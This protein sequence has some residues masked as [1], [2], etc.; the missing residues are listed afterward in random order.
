MDVFI[1]KDGK[2]TGPFTPHQIRGKYDRGTLRPEDHIWYNGASEW[3]PASYILAWREFEKATTEQKGAIYFLGEHVARNLMYL[4]AEAQIAAAAD[5]Q[6]RQQDLEAWKGRYAKC[7]E[8][9][10]WYENRPDD[11]VVPGGYFALE[12]MLI[13]IQTN[14]P[15]LFAAITPDE[16]LLRVDHFRRDEWRGVPATEAQLEYLAKLDVD[17][18]RGI[19]KGEAS[20]LIDVRVNGVSDGQRRRLKFYGLEVPT[21]KRRASEMIDAFM[22]AHPEVEEQYQQWKRDNDL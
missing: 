9:A 3:M 21:S 17:V 19:T 20:D 16:L 12:E 11:L 1:A 2:T 8:V 10:R 7:Q 6:G 14:N 5:R 18:P 22:S 15:S 4:E 13:K